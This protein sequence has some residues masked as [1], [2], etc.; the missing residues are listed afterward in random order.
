MIRSAMQWAGPTFITQLLS[1]RKTQAEWA[2]PMD[3]GTGEGHTR[4]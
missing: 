3:F 4:L 2:I 1:W